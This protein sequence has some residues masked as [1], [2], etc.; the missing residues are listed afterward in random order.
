MYTPISAGFCHPEHFRGF[1][2]GRLSFLVLTGAAHFPLWLTRMLVTSSCCFLGWLI[3]GSN[4]NQH[5]LW[6]IT[7]QKYLDCN[8]LI[9][10]FL[11]I[12]SHFI[13]FVIPV[14]QYFRSSGTIV[15]TSLDITPSIMASSLWMQFPAVDGCWWEKTS[16]WERWPLDTRHICGW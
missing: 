6:T 12:V 14:T 1:F 7:S 8:V 10:L 16:N 9:A 13:F 15:Y 4:N 11:A 5:Q 2:S 3:A